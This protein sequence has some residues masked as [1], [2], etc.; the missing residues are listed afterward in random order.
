M[1]DT[2]I[3]K[4]ITRRRQRLVASILGH[5]EREFYAQLTPAQ[6]R[7]FREKTL[8]SIDEF[9]DLMRD[10]LKVASDDVVLNDHALELLESLHSSQQELVEAL[11]GG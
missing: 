2:Q 6:Q 8:A 3:Q 1:A 11:R 4:L 7:A 5:A 10:V 9:C